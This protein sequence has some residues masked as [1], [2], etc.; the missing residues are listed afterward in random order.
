MIYPFCY[1]IYVLI[2]P[3][4]TCGVEYR[5]FSVYGNFTNCCPNCFYQKNKNDPSSSEL[6]KYSNI[7]NVLI[8]FFIC[9]IIICLFLFLEV[10]FYSNAMII[11]EKNKQN[12]L[13]EDIANYL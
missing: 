3:F 10:K 1:S 2:I 6:G 8:L 12:K 13:E 11:K 9:I 4:L 7:I 5:N